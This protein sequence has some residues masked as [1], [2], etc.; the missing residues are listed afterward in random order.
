M[1]VCKG[2]A[3]FSIPNLTSAAEVVAVDGNYSSSDGD[4]IPM[5]ISNIDND[6]NDNNINEDHP[7]G[8]NSLLNAS[9]TISK[10]DMDGDLR[11]VKMYI[12]RSLSENTPVKLPLSLHLEN[13]EI[14]REHLIDSSNHV[15]QQHQHRLHHH[16]NSKLQKSP[17]SLTSGLTIPSVMSTG[18]NGSFY[19]NSVNVNS[20]HQI[21]SGKRPA[22]TTPKHLST[23][24]TDFHFDDDCGSNSGSDIDAHENSS[25]TD[26][27]GVWSMD[28]EQCFQEALAIYPPCGRRKIIL[29][30]E[31][32]MYGRNE[33]IARYIYQHTGKIRSRKQVSSHI[34][35]LARRKSKELQAQIKDPD[36]KQRA[37]MHLS[38]LSSAQIVSASVLGSKT[39]PLNSSSSGLPI[40]PAGIHS[41]TNDGKSNNIKMS[42]LQSLNM[43]NGRNDMHSMITDAI[44]T[45]RSPRINEL[46]SDNKEAKNKT[47]G[48]YPENLHKYSSSTLIN[49]NSQNNITN[50]N[51]N[52]CKGKSQET[53]SYSS[54]IQDGKTVHYNNINLT[55]SSQS[56][57]AH[58]LPINSSLSPYSFDMRHQAAMMNSNGSP[59]SYPYE[60]FLALRSQHQSNLS[61]RN[62][63][64]LD[65]H[66]KLLR[67][68]AN[69][70]QQ[71]HQQQEVESQQLNFPL[72]LDN[73]MV[74]D[75]KDHQSQSSS[76][77]APS[78]VNNN[79]S[80]SLPTT[81]NSSVLLSNF[82]PDGLFL[83]KTSIG[84][85]IYCPSNQYNNSNDIPQK[86]N[87]ANNNNDS[88]ISSSNCSSI[89]SLSSVPSFPSTLSMPNPL[90][91][92]LTTVAPASA[93]VAMAA[94]HVAAVAAYE[95]HCTS[96]SSI[97]WPSQQNSIL[98]ARSNTNVLS[99]QIP[100]LVGQLKVN[101]AH[102]DDNYND[103]VIGK[104]LNNDGAINILREISYPSMDRLSNPSTHRNEYI[105]DSSKYPGK[106]IVETVGKNLSMVNMDPAALMTGATPE[107][108]T[109]IDIPTW[110]GRSVT[111]PK[112]R[113]VELSAYMIS[114]TSKSLSNTAINEYHSTATH[115]SAANQ[116]NFVHIGPILNEQLYTDPNL[117][118]VDASQ[119]W[120]KFPEDSLK[121]LMEHGPTNTFFLVKFW[122]DVNVMVES[123][124]TFAVSA[125]FEGTE[126]VPINLSTKVCSFGKEVLEKIED[127][128]PRPENGRYVYRF[129]RS[130]MCDYMKKFI[131]KLLQ[132][133]QRELMNSVLEN[134][135]ILHVLTNK[136]TNEVLLC[137]AYVL[138]VAQEGCR[139]QHHIYRLTRYG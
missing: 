111:A 99:K 67:S 90:D 22:P 20:S 70:Q 137:I 54:S 16:L 100:D 125:I 9:E 25:S 114:L 33:L 15:P 124:A 104:Q 64:T 121:E 126:D 87:G 139:A 68:D 79:H 107:D 18:S 49:N 69:K 6:N 83:V 31:G 71:Q 56:T 119:I 2:K 131:G 103:V 61:S 91:S 13:P 50:S 40:T 4:S 95:Q 92:S 43:T 122:A 38:M 17:S 11:S 133:P 51:K 29:S 37:I 1:E 78:L 45:K 88:S 62:L 34:Q 21:R 65:L 82:Q 52:L 81:T 35:V 117:E 14:A 136:L 36:T 93:A 134:F 44:V 101:H 32:K 97:T 120:D 89:S 24:S 80:R 48:L 26:V 73:L 39:L 77:S 66:D 5:K 3:A 84:Q 96:S 94:A 129:L 30:E 112:M 12:N 41:T 110:M 55:P 23:N 58:L 27:E 130:P 74:T 138:E 105:S 132:L 19:C 63:D 57:L 75:S 53:S 76:P 108:L 85:L 116:H 109:N 113:L 59:L 115:N 86:M 42:N 46:H 7:N 118:Q 135:T 60:A 28:I 128:Q 106:M 123:D 10:H 102:H 127:E 47:N 72:A 98:S 8:G